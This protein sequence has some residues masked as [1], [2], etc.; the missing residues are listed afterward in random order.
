MENGIEGRQE[1]EETDD[2]VA[3]W[4][5]DSCDVLGYIGSALLR[6]A[7]LLTAWLVT[8]RNMHDYEGRE[9]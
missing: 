9:E 1:R 6:G 4:I 7:G 8:G 2:F 3:R 5:M